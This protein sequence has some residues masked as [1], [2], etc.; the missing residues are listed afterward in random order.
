MPPR[1]LLVPLLALLVGAG[2]GHSAHA[3]ERTR[4]ELTDEDVEPLEAALPARAALVRWLLTNGRNYRREM[5]AVVPFAYVPPGARYD[6]QCT[7]GRLARDAGGGHV[8][9]TLPSSRTDAQLSERMYGDEA[10]AE[11]RSAGDLAQAMQTLGRIIG[12]GEAEMAA[13]TKPLFAWYR[14]QGFTKDDG[15][16][17]GSWLTREA[18]DGFRIIVDV[19]AT[20]AHPRDPYCQHLNGPMLTV[21]RTADDDGAWEREKALRRR[22]SAL[23][24]DP[25]PDAPVAK[26]EVEE[27][28]AAALGE[29]GLTEDTFEDLLTLV[30]GLRRFLADPPESRVRARD[31]RNALARERLDANLAWMQRHG[32][33][34]LPLVDALHDAYDTMPSKERRTP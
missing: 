6:G 19:S 31:R 9:F 23:P 5:D 21:M 1:S 32:G 22:L 24:V 16:S 25:D 29:A 28:Y 34:I 12:A 15:S 14:S 26:S 18:R 27:E 8:V 10:A 2:S 20:N 17:D 30:F 4:F 33:A 11:A 3:Q 13:S 7:H